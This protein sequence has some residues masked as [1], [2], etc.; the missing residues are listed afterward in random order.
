VTAAG[1]T[2]VLLTRRGLRLPLRTGGATAGEAVTLL[3]RPEKIALASDGDA[4][5]EGEIAEAIYLGDATRYVVRAGDETFVVKQQNLA[6]GAALKVGA[7][8]G[9]RWEPESERR[10]A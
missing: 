10:L 5:V 1:G 8:V 7:R 6:A 2:L 9:L 3:V 4:L